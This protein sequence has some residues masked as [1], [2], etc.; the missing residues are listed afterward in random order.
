LSCHVVLHI[1][2]GCTGQISAVTFCAKTRT[3]AAI[4]NLLGEPGVSN[5][6]IYRRWNLQ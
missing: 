3:K 5:T 6:I 1:T 2:N 4:K